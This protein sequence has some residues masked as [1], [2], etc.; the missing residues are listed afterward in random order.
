MFLILGLLL[1]LFSVYQHLQANQIKIQPNSKVI[2]RNDNKGYFVFFFG[3]VINLSGYIFNLT[4]LLESIPYW[5]I[6]FYLI[7][8]YLNKHYLIE[9]TADSLL[10]FKGK[11]LKLQILFKDLN[12]IEYSKSAAKPTSSRDTS[13]IFEFDRTIIFKFRNSSKI[14][15][16]IENE[17]INKSDNLVD[18]IL[19]S[20]SEITQKSNVDIIIKK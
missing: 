19:N 18:E 17:I 14:D 15:E 1:L 5:S 2:R 6:L 20:I 13:S 7:G 8:I 9:L 4:D 3:F 11:N 10:Y 12:E 16:K